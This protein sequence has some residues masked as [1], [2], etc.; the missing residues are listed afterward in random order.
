MPTSTASR[1]PEILD[2]GGV[3]YPRDAALKATRLFLEALKA[4][5]EV[6]DLCDLDSHIAVDKLAELLG[7]QD[8]WGIASSLL[9]EVLA[10]DAAA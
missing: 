1:L 2:I 3:T 6:P 7:G 8:W 9:D 10:E 4:L 5:H